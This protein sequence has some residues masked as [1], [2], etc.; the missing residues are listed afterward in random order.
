MASK[1]LLYFDDA[2]DP[3][4]KFKHGSSDF[5]VMSCV[6]FKNVI[7]AEEAS[8]AISRLRHNLGWFDAH[9]FKFHKTNL[10]IRKSFFIAIQKYNFEISYILIDKTKITERALKNST[11]LY[12][13]AIVRAMSVPEW[14]FNNASIFI[15][16]KSGRDNKKTVGSYFRQNMSLGAIGKI[17]YVNSASNNMIQLADMVAGAVLLTTKKNRT[18][19]DSYLPIIEKHIV[20]KIIEK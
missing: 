13:Y 20:N 19:H 11:K 16:G 4:F 5:F 12:N 14:K 7:D 8:E 3:G 18:D 10:Q 1:V 15:D 6:L 17:S 2:G 9:E